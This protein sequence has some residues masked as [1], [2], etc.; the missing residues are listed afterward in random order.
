MRI[1]T[2][3][4]Y[5]QLAPQPRQAKLGGI[6]IDELMAFHSSGAK[7]GELTRF[8]RTPE[9]DRASYLVSLKRLV[10]QKTILPDT[11]KIHAGKTSTSV[12][13]ENIRIPEA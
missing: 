2:K 7:Y 5:M 10:R 6:R 12:V 13:V 9:G 1:L 3:E 11:L 8:S 4:E